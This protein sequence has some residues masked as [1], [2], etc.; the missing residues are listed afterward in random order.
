MSKKCKGKI[1]GGQFRSVSTSV[2]VP[3]G[4]GGEGESKSW[5]KIWMLVPYRG[6]LSQE[7][8]GEDVLSSLPDF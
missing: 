8:V 5:S 6:T 1:P 3:L 7:Q 4:G 2:F